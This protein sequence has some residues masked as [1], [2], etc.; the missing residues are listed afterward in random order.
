MKKITS[1][2]KISNTHFKGVYSP[3]QNSSLQC[4]PDT[5]LHDLSANVS[6]N[7]NLTVSLVSDDSFK[8]D[9]HFYQ[10]ASY[11]RTSV[12]VVG[13]QC[14]ASENAARTLLSESCKGIKAVIA[15][16]YNTLFRQQ[17]INA[18]ILPLEFTNTDD[19]DKISLYDTLYLEQLEAALK[20]DA[21][22]IYNRSTEEFYEAAL[23]FD[24]ACHKTSA[25]IGFESALTIG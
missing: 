11:L 22:M 8:P 25:R 21:W 19:F 9:P 3:N 2:K 1:C 20:P 23:H 13:S 6:L 14:G 17:L 5:L 24:A 12:V 16:S 7:L 10:R 18:G 4:H 15:K